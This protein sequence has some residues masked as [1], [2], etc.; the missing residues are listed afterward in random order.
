MSH[1]TQINNISSTIQGRRRK[2][3]MLCMTHSIEKNISSQWKEEVSLD[4]ELRLKDK[5][6]IYNMFVR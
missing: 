5:F 2:R 4:M 6:G 1:S 3:L